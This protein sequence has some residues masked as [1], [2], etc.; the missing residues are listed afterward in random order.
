[1]RQSTVAW[2]RAAEV[3]DAAHG[4]LRAGAIEE[5]TARAI[6]ERFPDPCVTPS[7]VWRVLTAGVVAAVILCT[8]AA[9]WSAVRSDQIHAIVL[10]LFAGA[11]LGSADRLEGS[12]R[13]TRRG[14]AG[15]ASFLGVGFLVAGFWL[16]LV[17]ILHVRQ[18][19][20]IDVLLIASALAWAAAC[21]R[22]GSPLFAALSA[23]SVFVWLG[24][25][26]YG[27]VLWVVVGAVL[28]GIAARRLDEAS[29]APS[30]R[31]AAAVLVV[32]GI[33]A[34]YAAVNAYSF[35]THLLEHLGGFAARR[36]VATRIL[37]HLAGLATAVVPLAVL[38]WGLRS[39]RTFLIDT[40]IVL[41]A[42]SLL[43]LRHYVHVAP[44]WVVLTL[45]G[46]ALVV[47]A[48]AVDRAL[49]RARKSEIAGF[50]ANPLFSDERRQHTLQV[51]P[52]VGAFT[53]AAPG[54]AVQ[55]KNFT[56][57]GGQFG[58]GGAGD[59]F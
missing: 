40:G 21:L 22:W 14:V 19:D 43:T 38:A 30:H 45:S 13:F 35:D 2:E 54:P 25:L 5:P 10:L 8:L 37:V 56:G 4:W 33:A 1:M 7:V 15:A 20:A 42:L 49:R 50:T 46:A 58:G 34:V 27:R 11:A 57:G 52:V 47:L 28:A 24:Q 59:N 9:F 3:H 44:L 17:E 39:R 32:V 12:P 41:L 31:H 55:E 6:R 51:V 53:P 16:F 36:I 23:V 26:P 29:W 48:I 18:D